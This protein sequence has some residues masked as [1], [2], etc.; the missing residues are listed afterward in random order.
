MVHQTD[1]AVPL[2]EKGKVGSPSNLVDFINSYTYLLSPQ[3]TNNEGC[4][5]C[6]QLLW[7]N[8]TMVLLPA[9]SKASAEIAHGSMPHP[10]PIQHCQHQQQGSR[11]AFPLPVTLAQFKPA[12]R[13]CLRGGV[14]SEQGSEATLTRA[15]CL[16]LDR[17]GRRQAAFYCYLQPTRVFGGTNGEPSRGKINNSTED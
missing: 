15:G 7:L 11:P 14:T 16:W 2:A 4:S 8:T 13:C 1:I 5:Y 3:S 9:P 6:S 17:R 10:E 12:L